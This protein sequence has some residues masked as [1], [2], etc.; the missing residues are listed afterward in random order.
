MTTYIV[1]AMVLG[2]ATGG[3]IHNYYPDPAT[4]KLFATYISL[5]SMIFLRLIK[6]IVGRWCSRPWSWESATCP[7]PVQSEGSVVRLCFGSLAPQ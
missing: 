7:T 1:V 5:G 3:L 6:M 4:Q 2:I